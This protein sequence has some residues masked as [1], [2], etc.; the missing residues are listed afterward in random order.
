MPKILSIKE[1]ILNTFWLAVDNLSAA[2]FSPASPLNVVSV[3]LLY[4]QTSSKKE[5][6]AG[7][8][9]IKRLDKKG[10]KGEEKRKKDGKYSPTFSFV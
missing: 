7:E 10:R 1:G 4:L 9:I 2:Y 6:V 3:A 8:E 5:K